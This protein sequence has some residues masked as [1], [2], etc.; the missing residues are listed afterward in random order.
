MLGVKVS[1]WQIVAL[2][3]ASTVTCRVIRRVKFEVL[4]LQVGFPYAVN[5]MGTASFKISLRPGVYVVPIIVAS[6][7]V[8]SPVVDQSNPL[9]PETVAPEKVYV[10]P[11]QM[12]GGAPANTETDS[13]TVSNN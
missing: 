10:L 4:S 3:P 1:V 6:S 13:F 2:S 9:F 7:K 12:V 8:P 5:V 11:S